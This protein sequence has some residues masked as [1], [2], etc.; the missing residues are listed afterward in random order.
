[1]E[2]CC[3]NF[4]YLTQRFEKEALEDTSHREQIEAGYFLA[5]IWFT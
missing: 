1:M 4:L 3:G 5:K 2:M